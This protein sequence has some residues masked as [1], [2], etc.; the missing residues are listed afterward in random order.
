MCLFVWVGWC[1]CDSYQNNIQNSLYDAFY[2]IKLSH[3]NSFKVFVTAC[4]VNRYH[5]IELQIMFAFKPVNNMQ[6]K[7]S[8]SIPIHLKG[9]VHAEKK[10]LSSFAHPVNGF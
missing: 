10:I 3:C 4:V 9:I 7:L 2:A 6:G 8:V 5:H 1:L